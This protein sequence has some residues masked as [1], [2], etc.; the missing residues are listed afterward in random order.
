MAL[1]IEKKKKN[2][3]SVC[4]RSVAVSRVRCGCGGPGVAPVL[5]RLQVVVFLFLFFFFFLF[6]FLEGLDSNGSREL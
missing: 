1:R 5:S 2:G 6:F 4:W 3:E